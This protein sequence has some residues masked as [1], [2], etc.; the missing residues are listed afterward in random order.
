MK[1][2]RIV[3]AITPNEKLS[4]QVTMRSIC[5]RGFG[6]RADGHPA[7]E[8]GGDQAAAPHGGDQGRHKTQV[9]GSSNKY[10]HAF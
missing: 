4:D 10:H 1:L 7:E 2:E 3:S 6:R 8:A 5:D 9:D